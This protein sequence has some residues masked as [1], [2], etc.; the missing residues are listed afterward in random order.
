MMFHTNAFILGFLPVCVVGF[1]VLGRLYG[2]TSALRWLI[3][4]NLFFYAWWNPAHVPLLVA[5]V[6]GNYGIALRLR[7]SDAT[8]AWL[9]GGIVANLAL[10][11]WF[12]YADFLLHIVVPAAPALHITLPLAISFFTFQ[13]RTCK[14]PK[15]TVFYGFVGFCKLQVFRLPTRRNVPGLSTWCKAEPWLA[16]YDP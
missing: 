12:K 11:G 15:S 4:S 9:A 3:A 13:Q 8:R 7:H 1:F 5:S 6:L 2:A 16:T 10:L 14:P